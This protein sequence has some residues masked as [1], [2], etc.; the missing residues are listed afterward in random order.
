MIPYNYELCEEAN[1]G[2]GIEIV[3]T[4]DK[5]IPMI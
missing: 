1:D 3:P 2:C 4:H 5:T